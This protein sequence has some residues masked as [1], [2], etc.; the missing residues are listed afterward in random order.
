MNQIDTHC[1][2]FDPCRTSCP[3]SC[4]CSKCNSKCDNSC[5]IKNTCSLEGVKPAILSIPYPDIQVQCKNEYFAN[6]LTKDY[7]GMTSELTAITQY[8]NHEIRLSTHY[9]EAT[10]TLLSIAQAEMIHLQMLGELIILLGQP[11][12]YET[13]QNDC[14]ILWTPDFITLGTHYNDIICANIDGEYAAIKQ[15]EKHIK[16]ID[17]PCIT[18]ILKRIVMDEK[19]HVTLLRKLLK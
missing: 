9:C 4:N 16:K 15:Y 2:S 13:Q 14:T 10:Q 6:L 19:Y 8:I 5:K 11:L 18:A 3:T 7:C 12:T 1:K 17:D